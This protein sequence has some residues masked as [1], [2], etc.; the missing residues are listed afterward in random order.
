MDVCKILFILFN[1]CWEKNVDASSCTRLI[2]IQSN[3][4][5]TDCITCS[6]DC[7]KHQV[8]MELETSVVQVTW[9]TRVLT[10]SVRVTRLNREQS[11]SPFPSPGSSSEWQF[12]KKKPP[13]LPI[14][15]AGSEPSIKTQ[16]VRQPLFSP[17]A[18]LLT[19]AR[20]WDEPSG[21][22]RHTSIRKIPLNNTWWK[23]VCVYFTKK[24]LCLVCFQYSM[25]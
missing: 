9:M 7:R 19:F 11:G 14:P 13:S 18:L 16:N 5:L 1:H 25:T 4:L 10:W 23:Y 2:C 21:R 6:W 12:Y 3:A 17:A 20:T 8:H 24:L 22:E 15:T